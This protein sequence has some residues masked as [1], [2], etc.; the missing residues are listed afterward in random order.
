MDTEK[1][2][3]QRWELWWAYVKFEDSDDGK[4]RPV[5]VIDSSTA[6]I[7]SYKITKHEPRAEFPNEYIIK[8]W[9]KAGLKQ[10]STLRG[11]Q[12]LKLIVSDFK[13]K[14]GRLSAVDIANIQKMLKIK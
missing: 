9:Q 3:P 8:N 11:S 7:I 2:K 4:V 12:K 6:I 10:Q 5:L 14:I 13:N 1:I